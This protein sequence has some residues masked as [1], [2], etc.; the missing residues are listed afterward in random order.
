MTTEEPAGNEAGL[1]FVDLFAGLG[2]FHL[3]LAGL[4]HRCVMASEVDDALQKLYERN[5][6]FRPHGDIRGIAPDI[7]PEHDILCAGF[8]CQPY[9]KAGAQRGLECTRWGDLIKQVFRILEARR[10][11]YIILENVPNLVRHAGGETWGY[12]RRRLEEMDYGVDERRLSPHAFGVPQIRERS[13]IVGRLGGLGGFRWP[14]PG[15]GPV[16]EVRSILDQMPEDATP[17]PDHLRNVLA[18][19]QKLLDRLPIDEFLP[20]F[21]MWAMEWGATYPYTEKTPFASGWQGMEDRAGS[22]GVPLAHLEADGVRAALPPYAREE[23]EQFPV[24][25]VEFIRKN[26]EFYLRNKKCID[27]WLPKLFDFAPSFHKLEWNI[28]GGVRRLDQHLLQ[29]RASGIR[30]RS[31]SRAP[32][33][34]AFTTSQVPVIG[35]ENRYMTP[36]ECARLQSMD[37]LP[38]LPSARSPAFKALGNAVNVVVARAVAA[39]LLS[40]PNANGAVEDGRS[41]AHPAVP[42]PATGDAGGTKHA[43]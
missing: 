15:G 33:L 8:P 41:T 25:K 4:G 12:I 26:R 5:H 23:V 7:V 42:E 13:F 11:E 14:E 24:W 30:V 40:S 18:V 28:K 34:V 16:P 20:T 43:A 29:F 3:A 37:D 21:P 10:P 6:K 22:F 9:S 17:L 39:A 36:R 19:W 31:T 1:R 32:T 2:G 35:W 27:P 38:H